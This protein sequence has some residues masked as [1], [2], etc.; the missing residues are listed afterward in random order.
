[1]LTVSFNFVHAEPR[2]SYTIQHYRGLTD[3]VLQLTVVCD[4]LLGVMSVITCLLTIPQIMSSRRDLVAKQPMQQESQLFGPNARSR[5]GPSTFLSTFFRIILEISLCW[6]IFIFAAIH[7]SRAVGSDKTLFDTF[8]PALQI[9]WADPDVLYNTKLD[10]F[11]S[12]VEKIDALLQQELV[13]STIAF[14]LMLLCIVRLIG[15]MTVHP[16]INLLVATMI[17]A[18]DEVF[19]FFVSF[20]VIFMMFAMVAHAFFGTSRTEYATLSSALLTQ[21][22]QVFGRM[23]ALAEEEMAYIVYTV[24]LYTVLS[25]FLLKFFLAIIIASYNVVKRQ[26]VD[27]ITEQSI[28]TDT[29]DVFYLA[30]LRKARGWPT[31]RKI[32]EKINVLPQADNLSMKQLA[33]IFDGDAEKAASFAIYYASYPFLQPDINDVSEANGVPEVGITPTTVHVDV[34]ATELMKVGGMDA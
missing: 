6:A 27:Q 1:M 16:R 14:I 32:I 10:A 24:L 11:F 29:A 9:K 26:V 23:T 8:N 21:L 15:Y 18:A 12:S 4:I 30:I 33:G 17:Q 28:F 19:H 2:G 7:A 22:Y 13:V 3:D 20:A 25:L 5:V 31:H 34:D